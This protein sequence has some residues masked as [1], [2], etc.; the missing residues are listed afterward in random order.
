[1]SSQVNA[2]AGLGATLWEPLLKSIKNHL[3]YK[4][5]ENDI[6]NLVYGEGSKRW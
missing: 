3:T 4:L 2:D 1:M 6:T 5:S